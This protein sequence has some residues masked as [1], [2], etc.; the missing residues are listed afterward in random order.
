[1]N[2]M[3]SD[4]CESC[5]TANLNTQREGKKSLIEEFLLMSA[6]CP[7]MA[8]LKKSFKKK[9]CSTIITR[10]PFPLNIFKFYS[11]QLHG[12]IQQNALHSACEQIGIK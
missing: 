8:W 6:Q 1:M 10:P 12:S 4:K 3:L 9:T 5:S 7:L 2:W 11:G